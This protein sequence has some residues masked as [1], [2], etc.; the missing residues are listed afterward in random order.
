MCLKLLCCRG[1]VYIDY[2]DRH[3]PMAGMH[4]R[5]KADDRE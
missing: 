4:T 1:F 3:M 2:G 5:D